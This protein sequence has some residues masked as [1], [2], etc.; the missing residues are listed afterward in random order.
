MAT[1]TWCKYG[2]FHLA[3][4]ECS[5]IRHKEAAQAAA[6]I[7]ADYRPLM[8]PDDTVNPYDEQQQRRV[9]ELI[10]QA[11]PEVIITHAPNDYHTDHTNVAELV[12][13][14]GPILGIPQYETKSPPLDYNPALYHMDTLNGRYFEPTD[15]VN[16]TD[17]LETK[18]EMVKA[19]QSQIS[20]LKQYFGFDIL[21]QVETVARYRGIQ[22]GVRYAE[23]F[24]R[25]GSAGWGD[26]TR[27]YLP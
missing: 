13:W 26:L 2:C 25:C 7:G 15:Y 27:R 12:K 20:Y 11:R 23:A 19:Y 21:E 24:R 8:F 18:L 17:A 9:V 10:R 14:A 1:T 3:L 16:I 6:L 22:A 4:D 5:E